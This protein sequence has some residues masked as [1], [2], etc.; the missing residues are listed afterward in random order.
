[1]A[2]NDYVAKSGTL[3]FAPGD[4]SKTVSVA[5]TGDAVV[6]PNETL[7][8]DLTNPVQ[9][10]VAGGSAVGTITNDD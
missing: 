8:L 3:T 1:V 9:V 5:I 7:T 10:T 6:E 4:V 2:G